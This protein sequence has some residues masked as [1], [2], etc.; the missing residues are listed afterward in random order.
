M[1]F[2]TY[3]IYL[4]WQKADCLDVR[5]QLEAEGVLSH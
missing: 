5:L 4:K 2:A 3:L 1:R